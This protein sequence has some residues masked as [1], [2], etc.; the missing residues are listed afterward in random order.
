MKKWCIWIAVLLVIPLA[1]A[2]TTWIITKV[3]ATKVMA[4]PGQGGC[5]ARLSID[6]QQKLPLCKPDWVTF[7]CTGEYA[8]KDIAY[9]M[10]DSAQ[11]ALA[12]GKTVHL[13][14]TDSKTHNGFCF[15]RQIHV[16]EDN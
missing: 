11:M 9:R 2:D 3:L 12:L 8:S 6:L 4:E 14:I 1:Q 13:Q 15:V 7:S 5:L 10:F 16:T